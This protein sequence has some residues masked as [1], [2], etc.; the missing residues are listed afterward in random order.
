MRDSQYK[1][2]LFRLAEIQSSLFDVGANIATPVG[3]SETKK[4]YTDVSN[5]EKTLLCLCLKNFLV[6]SR[7]PHA[8][9]GAMDR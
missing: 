7:Q 2:I 6:V 5:Q 1:F 4:L 3:S 8:N 9:I